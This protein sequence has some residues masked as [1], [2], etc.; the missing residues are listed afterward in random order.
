MPPTVKVWVLT[1][2]ESKEFFNCCKPQALFPKC[3]SV[4]SQLLV[5][6]Y[7]RGQQ[8]V[9]TPEN[10]RGVN[11]ALASIQSVAAPDLEKRNYMAYCTAYINQLAQAQRDQRVIES[12]LSAAEAIDNSEWTP[13][14]C[15]HDLVGENIIITE[16]GPVLLDWEYA[17]LGHPA[18]DALR[19]FKNDLSSIQ[20]AYDS[21]VIG[22]LAILQQG[23]DDLWSLLQSN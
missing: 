11:S 16:S 17:A 3:T 21:A 4:I 20:G 23:M 10:R 18:L 8:W 13:V 9:D 22:Q 14:I 2:S 5:T 15:H 7:C 1:A 6:S 12:V 19:L